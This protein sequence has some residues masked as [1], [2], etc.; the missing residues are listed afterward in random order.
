MLRLSLL[1]ATA[2][3]LPFA[4]PAWQDAPAP[5]TLSLEVSVVLDVPVADVWEAFTTPEGITSWMAP[6]ADIDLAIGGAIRATYVEGDAL[7]GASTTV[8]TI[9]A[10]DPE[11]MLALQ[12]T[13]FPEGSPFAE[14]GRGTWAI[15]Y[16]DELADG[17]TEVTNVAHG[18][19]DGEDSRR[20]MGFFEQANVMLLEKLGAVLV[21]KRAAAGE[22]G[23]R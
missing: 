13:T 10:Y 6:V 7:G 22:T 23:E 8:M 1:L 15:F 3:A 5:G 19:R 2:A 20:M 17:R 21:A 4:V 9:L 14:V 12:T 18:Y 16:F 11:R